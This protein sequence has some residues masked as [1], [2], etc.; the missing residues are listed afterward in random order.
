MKFSF[1]L[2]VVHEHQLGWNNKKWLG[3]GSE[4][5]KGRG[6]YTGITLSGGQHAADNSAGTKGVSRGMDRKVI[7]DEIKKRTKGVFGP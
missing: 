5:G 7:K 4:A 2:S 1:S 3:P 6:N